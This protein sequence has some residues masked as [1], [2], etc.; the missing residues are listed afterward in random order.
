MQLAK[1]P[2][3]KRKSDDPAK[4]MVAQI[5]DGMG[6][7]MTH[8][9]LF[10]IGFDKKGFIFQLDIQVFREKIAKPKIMIT[11]DMNYPAI[12]LRYLI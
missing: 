10:V 1:N 8:Q 11:T 6:I 2:L 4:H 12:V 5:V 7:A 9:N 3:G